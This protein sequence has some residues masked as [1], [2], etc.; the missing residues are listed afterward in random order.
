ME[1]TWLTVGG[2]GRSGTTALGDALRE[3]RSIQ[4]F[5]EYQ[6][7]IFFKCVNGL[8][9]EEQRHRVFPKAFP[10]FAQ[11]AHQIPVAERDAA[12]IVQGIFEAVFHERAP[13]VGTKAPHFFM[14]PPPTMLPGIAE[15]FVMIT[16]NPHDVVLSHTLLRQ[17]MGISESPA[18][19]AE[20]G[21]AAWMKAWNHTVMRHGDEDFY[22]VFYHDFDGVQNARIAREIAAFLGIEPDFD[23]ASM[24]PRQDAD[25][26]ERYA[27]AK[28]E[29]MLAKVDRL[30]AYDDWPEQ[31][32]HCL[33]NGVL[34]GCPLKDG[35]AINFTNT[36]NSWK[37]VQSGF[38]PPERGGSWTMGGRSV[39][40]FTPAKPFAGDLTCELDVKRA[41]EH[42]N[43]AP[44]A[45]IRVN[46]QD[47]ARQVFSLGGR[48]GSG[49]KF[50]IDLPGL[51]PTPGPVVL[52]ICVEN[53]RSPKTL[54][55][56]NDDRSLGVKIRTL[57]LDDTR[58]TRGALR[59]LRGLRTAKVGFQRA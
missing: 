56:S 25:V 14:R 58:P 24:K 40:V 39:L 27:N 9:A 7:H 47:L 43:E 41:L 44:V 36:G 42:S 59:G 55:L 22:H 34:F 51:E 48:K 18:A 26:A 1:L 28:L 6:T 46:G 4:L 15:K 10:L 31:A 8:F 20:F 32:G 35:K 30:F 57:T 16:R 52:E 19:S 53:P 45:T 12:A 11:Y 50:R 29:H 37:Y 33:E 38:Y 5:H 54:G 49:R 21:L 17:S 23:L 3:S 13:V 2:C